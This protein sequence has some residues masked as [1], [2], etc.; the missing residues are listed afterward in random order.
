MLARPL[1]PVSEPRLMTADDD[2]VDFPPSIPPSV[3]LSSPLSC[4]SSQTLQQSRLFLLYLFR[5]DCNLIADK[6]DTG[7]LL[8]AVLLGSAV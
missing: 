5:S 7:Q 8:V 2:P 1:S 3:S 6:S 4:S